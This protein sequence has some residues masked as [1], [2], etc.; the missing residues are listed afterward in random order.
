MAESEAERMEKSGESSQIQQDVESGESSQ[1]QQDVE[2]GE[3]SQIQQDIESEESSQIQRVVESE[4]SSQIQQ[5][6]VESEESSQIQLD[7]IESGESSQ[8]QQADDESEESPEVVEEAPWPANK[9]GYRL[10]EIIG[11]GATSTIYRAFCMERGTICAIKRVDI[12]KHNLTQLGNEIKNLMA[13]RHA[14]IVSYYTSFQLGKTMWI[15][16][17]LLDCGSLRLIIDRQIKAMGGRYELN[18][19]V[20]SQPVIATVL[21]EVLLALD[22]IHRSQLVHGD[23]KAANILLSS[24]GD[25]QLA[26]FG[27]SIWLESEERTRKSM[28]GTLCYLA[29]E[30]AIS[31]MDYSKKPFVHTFT[32]DIWSLGITAMEMATGYPPYHN[33]IAT[34]TL[35]LIRES[36]PPSLEMYELCDYREYGRQYRHFLSLCLKKNAKQRWSARKLLTHPFIAGKAKSAEFLADTLLRI[37]QSAE[38]ST[39]AEQNSTRQLPPIID[40]DDNVEIEQPNVDWDFDVEEERPVNRINKTHIQIPPTIPPSAEIS[41]YVN[42]IECIEN[43]ARSERLLMAE[44]L[45]HS[46][47]YSIEDQVFQLVEKRKL[48]AR[49]MVTVVANLSKVVTAAQHQDIEG[50]YFAF[51][52]E[53]R[54][55]LVTVLEISINIWRYITDHRVPH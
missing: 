53:K 27:P 51:I 11:S 30:L 41:M 8:I 37:I 46:C 43:Q 48:E 14:N 7:V 33:K 44:E 23:I 38:P 45:F 39:S 49:L 2:S 10:D 26:D 5:D 4:E 13:C 3:S 55:A 50:K 21:K 36:D 6:V 42:I 24:E 40:I 28:P 25:V 12:E 16:M 18:K 32:L 20:L 47:K 54:K 22:Y 52:I 29:P 9:E 17:R 15:V 35:K 1:I 19:G 31:E 34:L